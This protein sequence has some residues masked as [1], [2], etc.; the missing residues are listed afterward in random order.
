VLHDI[1]MHTEFSTFKAMIDGK[2]DDVRVEILDKKTW[3]ELWQDYLSEVRHWSSKQR[4]NVFGNSNET[5]IEPNLSDKDKLNGTDKKLIGEFIR[6]HHAR[7]AHEIALK[8]FIGNEMIPFGNENLTKQDRQFI[9]IVARSHGTNIRNTFDYLKEIAY[10]VW[11]NPA[12]M[13]IVFLMVLLRIADY[14]QIDKNR[15]DPSILKLKTLN[16]P[17]S[18]QE[19]KMHLAISHL[20]FRN[21]DPELISV[22]AE[23]K[24]AQMYV[25]IQNLINDIQ[26]EFDLSWSILGEIYGFLPTEKPKIK[27]RRIAS[28]LEYPTFLQKIDYVPKKIAFEV[29]NELSKLLVA[30][31]YGDHPTYG[32]RELV[33]NAT[34]A[35]KERIKIEQDKEN[36]NYKPEVTVSVDK[37]DE[38]KYLFKIKDNGKGMTLDE[39]LNYFLSVGSSFRQ[40]TEWKKEFISSEGKSL[41]SRNGKFGIGVLAAFLLGDE[42]SVKTKNC[43]DNQEAFA[44]TANMNSDFIDIKTIDSFDIGTEIAISISTKSNYDSLSKPNYNG[45][46]WTDW[47]IGEIPSVQYLMEED[48]KFPKEFFTPTK[49]RKI[50]PNKYDS[51]QWDYSKKDNI[52]PNMYVACNNITITLSHHFNKFSDDKHVIV[53]KPNLL[54][55]DTQG[56]LPLKLNRNDLDCYRLPFEDEL[57]EDVAKDFIAQLLVMPISS[58]ET[59]KKRSVFP[60]NA[61]FLYSTNGFSLGLDYFVNK[62]TGKTLLRVLTRDNTE[63]KNI[64]PIFAKYPNLIISPLFSQLCN[65][66]G[67]GDKVAPNT[68]S[69]ILLRKQRYGEYFEEERRIKKCLIDRHKKQWHNDIFVSYTMCEYQSKLSLFDEAEFNQIFNTIDNDIQSIQEIPI[70]YLSVQK[71]GVILNQ[72][73]E[74]YFG[75]NVIIPYDMEERKKHYPLAFQELKDYMKDYEK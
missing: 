56:N 46:S 29:N 69:H 17:T 71:S 63:I 50:Y 59:I 36:P 60:H 6:R 58:S 35:C 11:R 16:S 25:K 51:V 66:R 32:V 18:I 26:H 30:P 5:I 15:T 28:N 72:L 10:G 57:F 20:T 22:T 39:I 53:Y 44:F 7:L 61:D 43:K 67:Q 21:K 24:N 52:N 23:P 54:I 2:Y 37:V 70:K 75:D 8:D 19:H 34:D 27:F 41:V 74:K 68:N 73:F 13:N 12:D 55:E 65:L 48:Q 38:G 42:I 1:G 49:M 14:L 3:L 45:I 31:L 62:I 40:S 4:E 33:Q 64:Y 47:Y 9:G